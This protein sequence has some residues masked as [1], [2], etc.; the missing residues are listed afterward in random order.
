M[1]D[2]MKSNK[3]NNDKKINL[4]LL[5]KIGK[6]TAPNSMKMSTRE[7]QKLIPKII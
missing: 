4:I 3:K 2:F 1:I 6:P 7:L 5:R